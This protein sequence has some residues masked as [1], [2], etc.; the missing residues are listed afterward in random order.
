MRWANFHTHCN[1]CHGTGKP[2]DYIE[3][4][5]KRCVETLGFSCHAFLP[6]Y[7]G[8]TM[9]KE[10]EKE[11]PSIV[12]SLQEN[13]TGK[14]NIKL[15]LEIDYIPGVAGTNMHEY[16][17]SMKLDYSIGSVHYIGEY[18][19][20]Q[21]IPVDAGEKEFLIGI[22]D[23]YSGDARKAVEAYYL[24][25]QDMV[26][27]GS[28][29]IVGHFDLIKKNNRNSKF[30]SE[31]EKWYKDIVENTLLLISK[32]DLIIE[33]NTG[34]MSRNYIDTTYPSP[35]IL[36]QCLKLKIP[37]TLSSDAHSPSH[38]TAWFKD[39]AKTLVDIGFKELHVLGE[40]GWEPRPFTP[41]G[42]L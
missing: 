17:D 25:L 8:W 38:V 42:L 13:Y 15:G 22:K 24:I 26:R 6:F 39:T 28:F 12:R 37:I 27:I 21:L 32:S 34:G 40:K 11:Y 19:S 23:A 31:E 30:F 1:L 4:A 14:I 2:E 3:E 16:K 18:H 36:E 7:P 20:G 9:T 29:D 10:I 33:V 41:Q 35:W 5:I